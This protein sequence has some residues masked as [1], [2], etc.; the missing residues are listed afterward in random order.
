MTIVNG[1]VFTRD[2]SFCKADIEISGDKISD[3]VLDRKG[4]KLCHHSLIDAEGLY[5]IPGLVDIH[6]HGAAGFDFCDA[7]SEAFDAIVQYEL[8]HGVTSLVLATMT[9]S[10]DRLIKVMSAAEEYAKSNTSIK[11]ITMEGPF[12]SEKKKGAQNEL[13]IKAPDTELFYSLQTASGGLIKQ[14][15]VAPELE[16]AESFIKEVS[17]NCVVSLA[18]TDACY[19]TAKRA[20]EAGATHVTHLYNAMP[21]FSHRSPSVVGA[22]FDNKNIFVELICDGE[23]IHPCVVRATFEMF[24]ADR[25]CMI[26]D[27]MS[28]TGKA[29]GEHYL[30]GQKVFVNNS[31]ATLCDGTLAGAVTTLYDNLKAAVKMGIPLENAIKACTLTPAMSLGLDKE[32]GVIDKVRAADMV[33]LD[34]NLDIKYVIK[35]GKLI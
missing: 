16:A 17:K 25:I 4:D 27:S 6:L 23:H 31:R 7:S 14:V 10:D 13:Y 5:V 30:G 8:S 11:G 28:A 35:D 1:N 2:C 15:T 32:C 26:S 3:I 34:R 20:F 19:E 24:G 22:A 33:L 9:L 21:A 12:I 18:H 29:D